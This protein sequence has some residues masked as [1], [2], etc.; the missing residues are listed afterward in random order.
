MPAAVAVPLIVGGVTAGTNI[1]NAHQQG[2]SADR[3]ARLQTDAANQAAQLQAQAAENALKFQQEQAA[4]AQRN[5]LNTQAF[6][7]QVYTD[8]QAR[9]SPY[10][11]A[12]QGAINQLGMPIPGSDL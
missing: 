2:N 11:R 5:F 10:R 7:R 3:A 6:N 12:G 4:L 1:F 9:L 8:Q